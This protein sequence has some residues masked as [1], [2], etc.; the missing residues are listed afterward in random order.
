MIVIANVECIG[1]VPEAFKRI[2]NKENGLLA[3]IEGIKLVENDT[4]IKTL[5]RV[6]LPDILGNVTIDASVM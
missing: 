3:I 2:K 1:G 4:K 5:G 6:S